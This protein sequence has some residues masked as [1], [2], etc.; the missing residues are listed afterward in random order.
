MIIDQH[1][2]IHS[3]LRISLIERCN[4]RCTY[5]MPAEGVPLLPKSHIMSNEEI[6][7]IARQFVALG[8]TKI[9]L[10]GGEPLMRKG[11][12][13]IL[14][15]LSELEV[16]LAMTTNAILLDQYWP[17]LLRYG[18][19]QLNIS[20]D[21]LQEEKMN[22]LSRRNKFQKIMA[23]IALAIDK[24]FDVKI[25]VVLLKG[26]NDQEIADFVAW[27]KD[28]PISIRFIEFMP[29]QGNNWDW[30]TN[31]VDLTE[32]LTVV[33]NRFG[34][35]AIERIADAPNDTTKNY[36]I[37]GAKG[38]FGVIS[39][40]SNPF[41]DTCNRIR[42]TADGK[43]KN[44]LFSNKETDVLGAFRSHKDVKKVILDGVWHKHKER[45]GMTSFS[46]FSDP[47]KNQDNRSMIR[48]GG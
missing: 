21:S 43:M 14:Q 47:E 5:C 34:R 27:G 35:D 12:D 6:V 18:V 3:Y 22:A 10:T 48:I 32:V 11:L 39:T 44:C 26:Q 36:R 13:N 25:N 37:K 4:L 28:L 29:F 17:L 40:V 38:T 30:K 23:N 45:A 15:G 16:S 1:H 2:R 8:V 46:A 9:R 24:G 31:G 33:G 42:L 7:A 41:C 20:L 19:R